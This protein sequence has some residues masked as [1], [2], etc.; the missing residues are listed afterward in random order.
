M[1]Y[2][3]VLA[4]ACF[5]GQPPAG[6]DGVAGHGRFMTV[7]QNASHIALALAADRLELGL[8]AK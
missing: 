4:V 1:P 8:D 3:F 7:L 5:R 6:S 2:V